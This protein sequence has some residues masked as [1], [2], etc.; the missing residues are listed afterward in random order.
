[1]EGNILPVFSRDFMV[2]PG[3]IEV[4]FHCLCNL[5]IVAKKNCRA[6]QAVQAKNVTKFPLVV[7]QSLN[8]F[9]SKVVHMAKDG[10]A[11]IERAKKW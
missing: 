1:M 3:R 5:F 2:W 4:T 10:D 8:W 11:S 7:T 9:G 6:C